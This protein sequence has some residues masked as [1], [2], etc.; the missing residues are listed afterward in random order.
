[1]RSEEEIKYTAAVITILVGLFKLRE[2]LGSESPESVERDRGTVRVERPDGTVLEIDSE[3]TDLYFNEDEVEVQ[4]RK[5]FQTIQEDDRIEG[6]TIEDPDTGEERF[7]VDREE[8]ERLAGREEDEPETRRVSERVGITVVR[9]V[10]DQD[11]GWE[12]LYQRDSISAKIEDLGFWARVD[13][14]EESFQKGDRLEV[15]LERKQEFDPTIND[16]RTVDHRITQVYGHEPRPEQGD[17][18]DLPEE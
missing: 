4:L 3:V 7:H 9:I 14:R 18:F 2:F 16:W 11:R 10:F 17:I 13:H 12:F 6:F 15:E 5:H 1:M 8:F